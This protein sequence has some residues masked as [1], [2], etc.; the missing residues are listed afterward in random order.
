[1][2]KIKILLQCKLKLRERYKL[3]RFQTLKGPALTPRNNRFNYV[4]RG[5]TAEIRGAN[6]IKTA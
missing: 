6:T 2:A 1:M 3:T 5:A 4:I